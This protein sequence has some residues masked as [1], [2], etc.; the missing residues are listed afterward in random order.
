MALT[1]STVDKISVLLRNWLSPCL[2]IA[3]AVQR[4]NVRL[5]FLVC[6]HTVSKIRREQCLYWPRTESPAV[7]A[8]WEHNQK[9][10]GYQEQV[11]HEKHGT[12][13]Y[14]WQNHRMV[15]VGRSHWRLSSPTSLLKQ[16]PHEH[17]TQDCVQAA[18]EFLQ[19]RLHTFPGQSVSFFLTFRWNFQWISFCLISCPS[20]LAPLRWTCL[21]PL[22][23]LPSDACVLR[24]SPTLSQSKQAQLPQ[25]FLLR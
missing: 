16:V 24:F 25:L 2:L 13:I 5:P 20:S 10:N 9:E 11:R 21:H 17:G 12:S 15:K 6:S 14:I 18:F 19:M 4:P 23:P 22:D 1:K 8:I 3:G 7:M